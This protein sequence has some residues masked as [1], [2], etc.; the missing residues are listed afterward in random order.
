M[1]KT[2]EVMSQN[3]IKIIY[4]RTVFLR[5]RKRFILQGSLICHATYEF[6]EYRLVMRYIHSTTL[7]NTIVVSPGLAVPYEKNPR[8]CPLLCNI[9]TST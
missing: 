2:Q 8:P 5:H 9:P 1:A 7:E 3:C 4:F 6:C